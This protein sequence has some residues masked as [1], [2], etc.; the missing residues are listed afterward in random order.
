VLDFSRLFAK[1]TSSKDT[2]KARLQ[3]VLVQDRL[4]C[5]SQLLEALKSDILKVISNY[6]EIDTEGLDIQLTQTG[7]NDESGGQPM[8]LANIPIKSIKKVNG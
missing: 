2:A 1:K 3:L 4:N 7:L 5:S 8:L 6:M